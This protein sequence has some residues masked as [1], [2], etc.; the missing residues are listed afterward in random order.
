MQR[1][2]GFLTCSTCHIFRSVYCCVLGKE[3]IHAYLCVPPFSIAPLLSL[4]QQGTDE[5]SKVSPVEEA[6]F[7]RSHASDSLHTH[8]HTHTDAIH[9]ILGGRQDSAGSHYRCCPGT[10][11]YLYMNIRAGPWLMGVFQSDTQPPLTL[12]VSFLIIISTHLT[13]FTIII[14]APRLTQVSIL[15]IRH[16]LVQVLRR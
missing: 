13:T 4:P 2:K 12:F 1:L 7:C 6:A 3:C 14:S 9:Y 8:T 5:R 15:P 16:I 11:T 10:H